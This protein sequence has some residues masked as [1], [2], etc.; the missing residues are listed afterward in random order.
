MKLS[1]GQIHQARHLKCKVAPSRAMPKRTTEEVQI[2]PHAL[3]LIR[4]TIVCSTNN[5]IQAPHRRMAR[6]C[7]VLMPVLV[8]A[9]VQQWLGARDRGVTMVK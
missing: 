4:A 3:G 5:T 1:L 2:K 7:K 8:P 6:H 9:S